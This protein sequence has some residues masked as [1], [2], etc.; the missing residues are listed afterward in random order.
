VTGVLLG[1]PPPRPLVWAGIAVVAVGLA[2]GLR[3]ATA[4]E[5]LCDSSIPLTSGATFP[6]WFPGFCT[7]RGS[8]A[9]SQRVRPLTALAAELAATWS[10]PSPAAVLTPTAPSFTFGA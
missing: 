10:V 8:P 6:R 2:L 1:A 9:T 5:G 3:G 7:P 4:R